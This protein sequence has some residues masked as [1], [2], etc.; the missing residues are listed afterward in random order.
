MDFLDIFLSL[1]ALIL[2]EVI[3]GIDNLIFLSILI[4]R[5]PKE[6]RQKAR[7]WGLSIAWISR[8]ILLFFATWLVKLTYPILSYANFSISIRDIFL[9]IGGGFLIVKATQEIHQEVSQPISKKIIPTQSR[10]LKNVLLQVVFIDLILSLDSVL[11]AIGLTN[12]FWIMAFAISTSILAMLFA[13]KAVSAFINKHPS[14]K[15]LALNF[16]IL[17]GTVLIADSFSFH[18]PRGYI[19]FAM[20][21]SLMTETLNLLQRSRKRKQP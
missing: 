17:I 3:L 12:H 5:L 1:S 20:G 11:T 18:V 9:F 2:L 13:S 8:I 6:E 4:D 15:M 7:F 14:I 16:L 10:T 19:Y 21:F